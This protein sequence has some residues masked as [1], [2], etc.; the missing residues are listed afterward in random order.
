[1]NKPKPQPTRNWWFLAGALPILLLAIPLIL[2]WVAIMMMQA[3]FVNVA[4]WS[5]WC[6]RGRNVLFIYSDSIASR[7]YVEQ[8]ILPKLAGRVVS[9]NWSQ[10]PQRGVSLARFTGQYFCKSRKDRPMAV[11]F[12]PFRPS[13][14]FRFRRAFLDRKHGRLSALKT[15]ERELFGA[16][17]ILENQEGAA[18]PRE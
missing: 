11:V 6:T 10:R 15:M 8:Q 18:P 17:R 5:W 1:M 7:E 2:L 9:V 13:R 4:I 12:R 16:L 3:M 14:I